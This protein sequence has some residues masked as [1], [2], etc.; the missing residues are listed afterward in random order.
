MYQALHQN[1]NNNRAITIKK[2]RTM[3][4]QN[5]ALIFASLLLLSATST[6]S[7]FE[8][9]MRNDDNLK[10]FDRSESYSEYYIEMITDGPGFWERGFSKATLNKE[11]NGA[12]LSSLCYKVN[13][14]DSAPWVAG[15]KGTINVHY[16]S[17]SK[18]KKIESVGEVRKG[19]DAY[20]KERVTLAD[21]TKF[22]TV[23]FDDRKFYACGM[24]ERGELAAIPQQWVTYSSTAS[25]HPENCKLFPTA[26]PSNNHVITFGFNW[27]PQGFA[28]TIEQNQDSLRE[29][30]STCEIAGRDY[31]ERVRKQTAEAN[32]LRKQREEL[33]ATKRQQEIESQ[34]RMRQ[35]I[36][37]EAENM[38]NNIRIGTKTNCGLVFDIRKPMIGVQTMIGMQYISLDQ[39]WGPSAGCHFK[40]GVYIGPNP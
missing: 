2:P 17:L 23:A 19:Q 7:A 14:L 39:L 9:N 29:Q 15:G 1:K 18:I 12:R 4:H 26:N 37:A 3:P 21:G 25:S 11:A 10:Y 5:R 28:S 8:W 24:T 16:I 22:E 31:A 27:M 6:A 32:A 30:F 36:L 38:R 40:N 20:Y 13:E 34:N 33:A 35:M